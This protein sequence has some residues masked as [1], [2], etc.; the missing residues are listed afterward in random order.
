[1]GLEIGESYVKKTL[2]NL[3]L[4]HG[5]SYGVFW[6]FDPQNHILLTVE[7]AY[8]ENHVA[9]VMDSV[10][11]QVHMF[12]EGVIGE[13]AFDGK[14]RWM[15]V[16][17]LTDH[18]K[19][20]LQFSAG[21]KT[22]AV[23][24]VEMRGVVQFGSTKEVFE[25]PEILDQARKCLRD[26]VY[27]AGVAGS[28]TLLSNSDANGQKGLLASVISSQSSFCDDVSTP[29]ANSI[30]GCS[31]F[32]SLPFSGEVFGEQFE[33]ALLPA[34]A[35][36]TCQADDLSQ[37]LADTSKLCVTGFDLEAMLADDMSSDLCG[38]NLFSNIQGKQLTFPSQS[39]LTN[40]LDFGCGELGDVVNAVEDKVNTLPI[41]DGMSFSE[42]ISGVRGNST[43]APRKGLF[44]ELGLEYLLK[45]GSSSSSTPRSCIEDQWPSSK[46]RKTE[47]Y[48]PVNNQLQQTYHSWGV[49]MMQPTST[50][51]HKMQDFGSLKDCMDKA[52][53]RLW[54]DESYSMDAKSCVSAV[55]T[56]SKRTEE[57]PKATKKRARPGESTRP[58][59]KDRQLIADRIKDLR[60]LIPNGAKLSIDSLLNRTIKHMLFLQNLNKHARKLKQVDESK[61]NGQDNGLI[62][63]S[64][65]VSSGGSGRRNAT[66]AYEVGGSNLLCPIIVEDLNEPGQMLIE[67]LCEERGYFLEIADAVRGFGLTILKGVME[68]RNDK[69]WAHF[70]VEGN[71]HVTRMDVFVSLM[72]LLQGTN[73]SEVLNTTCEAANI[74]TNAAPFWGDFQQHVVPLPI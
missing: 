72:Q 9:S 70:T 28:N 46:K 69:I 22:V 57:P 74:V 43:A 62:G 48:Q 26:S 35:L 10:P 61:L 2:R 59:P 53:G 6:R 25:T 37:W 38:G 56:Q 47:A 19:L 24:P 39:S 16:N 40:A 50:S 65:S 49:K 63:S 42:C 1:M 4:S 3:C 15:F 5:W 31:L 44:T 33:P 14:H 8:Y 20:N 54:I 11:L 66:W 34:S 27:F 32:D 71:K 55:N 60:D 23:I 68:M 18:C 17:G 21:I 58:R 36:D 67:M 45:D 7:D 12:G 13:A 41:D 29:W 51:G 64:T 30:E 52:Q 73:T